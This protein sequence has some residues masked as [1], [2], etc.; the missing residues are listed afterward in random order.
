MWDD[1]K[2]NL[3]RGKGHAPSSPV[4]SR[5]PEIVYNAEFMAIKIDI[6]MAEACGSYYTLR[7][8]LD[9]AL[10]ELALQAD[11]EYHTIYYDDAVARGIKGSPSLWINGKD[12]FEGGSAPGIT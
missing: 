10:E 6:Y 8:N 3:S 1:R 9:C 11:I 7:E 2:F 5:S 4:F 12:A